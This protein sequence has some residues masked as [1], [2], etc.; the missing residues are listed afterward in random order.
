VK[1]NLILKKF[2]VNSVPG[3]MNQTELRTFFG[4]KIIYTEDKI[5]INDDAIKFSQI[6][7][8]TTNGNNGY[9]YYDINTIPDGWEVN[10]NENLSDLKENNQIISPYSQ[11][12]S[13]K[14]NNTRWQI[15]I[16]GSQIL[17]DYLFFKIKEQR[18][19]KIIRQD[20]IYS[21]D[22]NNAIYEYINS[23]IFSRYRLDTIQFY[24]NYYSIAD[25]TIYNNII[26]QYNPKFNPDVYKPENLT[27]ISVQGYDPYN[28][29][30]ITLLYNQNKTSNQYNFEYYFDL[31]F[32]K[33]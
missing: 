30:N 14:N 17:K 13:D 19:F 10:Y 5:S 22:I 12:E 3:T 2:S 23:N 32:T 4:G 8:D 25:Q 16:N 1:S 28:F 29:N 18:V 27:N 26:L 20:D 11:T 21:N 31:N 7:N 24:V 15:N 6:V 33:I 9:Q